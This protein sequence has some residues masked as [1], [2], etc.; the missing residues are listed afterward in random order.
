MKNSTKTLITA[1]I[2]FA[3]FLFTFSACKEKEEKE[4]VAYEE[5]LNETPSCN[6]EPSWFPHTQTPAPEEGKGS[7]FDTTSTTNC[8]FHQWSWQKFLYLTKPDTN[9]K[10]L[11]LNNLI[12]VDSKMDV[13]VQQAGASLVLADTAQAG[14]Q[15]VLRSNP[16]FTTN[17]TSFTV[18][19]G[20]FI[21]STL[22]KAAQQ[23]KTELLNG[24]LPANNSASFPVGSLEMKS[25]WIAV[26]ALSESDQKEYFITEAAILQKDGSYLNTSVALLGMHVVGVVENHPEFIW[27]TFEHNDMTPLMDWNSL[28][29]SSES[30]LLF[31]AEGA[32]SNLDGISWTGK[33][34]KV[35]NQ[36]YTLFQYG[37][38]KVKGNGYLSTSQAEPLNVD[39]INSINACVANTLNDVWNNYF[40]NGSLWINMD[41]KTPQEQVALLISLSGNLA[42]SAPGDAT[43]G[44]V[45]AAN[46]TMETYVQTGA[47]ALDSI[48][49][50]SLVSCFSCHNAENFSAGKPVSPLYISHIFNGYIEASK[51][52][53]L[54]EINA[55]KVNEF[56]DMLRT[57]SK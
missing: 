21:D 33:T 54:D 2:I 4:P 3:G 16:A 43:R 18:F 6:C 26:E 46:S 17:E 19:Y 57:K 56:K 15:G 41:G 48:S 45:N 13:I 51:G 23:F 38:P 12:Q 30:N 36:A 25:S 22:Q 37:V 27:A 8:I 50:A 35:A 20:I 39:N 10:P 14:S 40:Y 9:G 24:T 32:A 31:F 49:V 1:F 28:T 42:N 29:A 5:E 52:K 44:S 55:M 7:P 11:F 34:P 53:T 47:S